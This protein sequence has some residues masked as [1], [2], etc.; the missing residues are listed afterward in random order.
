MNINRIANVQELIT[1]L[2]ANP[3]IV[4]GKCCYTEVNKNGTA[5][6]KKCIVNLTTGDVYKNRRLFGFEGINH[7]LVRQHGDR[8]TN[9]ACIMHW[10]YR[11][12]QI[13]NDKIVM[14]MWV[15]MDGV[16]QP[17]TNQLDIMYYGSTKIT[18]ARRGTK[19][20]HEAL[21]NI[22]VSKPKIAAIVT[23]DKNKNVEAW[24]DV[25]HYGYKIETYARSRLNPTTYLADTLITDLTSTNNAASVVNM[26]RCFKEFFQIGYIGANKYVAFDSP[27]EIAPFMKANS[28]EVKST[29]KQRRIDE[30]VSIAL[31]NHNVT[32]AGAYV[33]CY[34][35]RANDEWTAMRWY[36]RIGGA[37]FYETSRMYVS[38]KEHL[39]CR[40]DLKGN[41]VFAGAKLK[42]ETFY[43]DKLVLQTPDVFDG[44]KLEY[45]KDISSTLSNRTAALYM[46]TTYPEFEK[47]YKIGLDWLCEEYLTAP[48][49]QSWP[50]F[51]NSQVGTV[52]KSAKNIL[53]FL[54]L[55]R[56][57]FDKLMQVREKLKAE[58][59]QQR[60]RHYRMNSIIGITKNAFNAESISHID[61][62]TFDYIVDSFTFA[63]IF[64]GSHIGAL[65]M[66]FALYQNDAIYFIRDMINA[67]DASNGQT[68]TY[69]SQ[70]G[71]P[72]QGN[73]IGMYYDTLR[74]I[75][76]YEDT[77][78][79][80]PRFNSP[81]ELVGHHAVM[82][83]LI[84]AIKLEEEAKRNARY[85]SGFQKGHKKWTKW[86]WE[87]DEQ[88]CVIAPASPIDLANEGMVLRH[89][90]KSYIPNVANGDT[91][92]M[93]IRRKG[94][95]QS[96]FFTVE[97]DNHNRIRQVHGACNSITDSIEGLTDFVIQWAKRN[98]FK[99]D[100]EFAN[101]ARA[102]GGY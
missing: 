84:N 74:M 88:F 26:Q 62:E 42:A 35:D 5:K 30:L 53:K 58:A 38:K 21:F 31:P 55:S 36:H 14:S 97:V 43:A 44:T 28:L 75:Q 98:K 79:L 25:A 3:P 40:F 61:K 68:F 89:C 45:F 23:I 10:G 13:I 80:R 37:L 8:H 4:Y 16:N 7:I 72:T 57:Q 46:L 1:K 64:N 67:E 54:G 76:S 102:A 70:W 83:D 6:E 95:E 92:I 39:H 50:N 24:S 65:R 99:Y 93:F 11:C 56:Y 86:E 69:R 81:E 71:Y 22:V 19:K 48:W 78:V 17:G 41:W 52:D 2:E 96:P 29:P 34:A 91:N 101:R 27:K 12:A 66:T 73:V 9:Q 18:D 49:Q 33:I 59:Q 47:M 85:E 60:Y 15:F 63:R 77:R 20:D 32:D 82:V 87:G 90:V 94:F 51:L 100:V